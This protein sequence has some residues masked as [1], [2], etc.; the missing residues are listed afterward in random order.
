MEGSGSGFRS[1]LII[2]DT[3]P[4]SDPYKQPKTFVENYLQKPYK[5][6]IFLTRVEYFVA[7]YMSTA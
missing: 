7:W 3:E 1:V 5:K 4:D 2:T 6:I